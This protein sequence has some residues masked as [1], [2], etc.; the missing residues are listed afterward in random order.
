MVKTGTLIL[1]WMQS[2]LH[3][4]ALRL[5]DP[6][7]TEAFARDLKADLALL[8][9]PEVVRRYVVVL[10]EGVATG[11][12]TGLG[13]RPVSLTRFTTLSCQLVDHPVLSARPPDAV[14]AH[15]FQPG[16]RAPWEQWIAAHWQAYRQFH[17]HNPPTDLG[18]EGLREVF[19]GDDLDEG[20]AFREGPQGRILGFSSLREESQ[21][22]WI[23]TVPGQTHLLPA[24]MGASLRRAMALGWSS[25]EIEVDDEDRALWSLIERLPEGENQSRWVTWH[26]ERFAEGPTRN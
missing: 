22:G 13:F 14:A 2:D 4:E 10:R 26:L 1:P 3:P 23:A 20:L 11:T 19:V 6:P 16:E 21:L 17:R 7:V 18:P 12:M 9:P 5:A 8:D 15:W 25:A 24:L